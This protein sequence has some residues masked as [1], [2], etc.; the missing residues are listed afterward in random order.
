MRAANQ[1]R[2]EDREMGASTRSNPR[3]GLHRHL[4]GRSNVNEGT[5]QAPATGGDLEQLE[6]MLL[7]EV[8]TR[9]DDF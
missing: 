3:G 8:S 4:G 1:R 7:M 6:E 2:S 9:S 5:R